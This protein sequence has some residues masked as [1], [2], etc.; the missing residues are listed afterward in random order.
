MLVRFSEGELTLRSSL[1][2][3]RIERLIRLPDRRADS[4]SRWLKSHPGV[5][6][7]SRDRCTEYLRGASAGAPDAQQVI[8]R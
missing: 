4:F 1:I 8:D 3:R 7:I 5:E 6:V 2:W